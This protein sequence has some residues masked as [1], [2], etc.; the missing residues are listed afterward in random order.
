VA[1]AVERGGTDAGPRTIRRAAA[2]GGS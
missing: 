2:A 1:L